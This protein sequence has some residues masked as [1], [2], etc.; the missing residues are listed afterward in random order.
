MPADGHG[1]R[2]GILDEFLEFN[3]GMRRAD[4]IVP[5]SAS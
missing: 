5:K 3:L 2:P 4:E 1:G